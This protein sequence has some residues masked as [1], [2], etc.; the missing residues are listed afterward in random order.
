[1]D[2]PIGETEDN[3]KAFCRVG[4]WAAIVLLIYSLLTL[5]ILVRLGGAPDTAQECFAMIQKNLVT[6]LLRLD[7]LT[8]LVMPVF[9]LLYAGSREVLLAG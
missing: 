3:W 7:V 2:H 5:V 4:A 8:I 1:M 6:A 9:C